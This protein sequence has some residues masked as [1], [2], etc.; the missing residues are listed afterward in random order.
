MTAQHP[1]RTPSAPD[2]D[3]TRDA[4][5]HGGRRPASSK[6]TVGVAAP[7]LLVLAMAPA[8]EAAKR[9]PEIRHSIWSDLALDRRELGNA[10]VL[11]VSPEP[12]AATIAACLGAVEATGRTTVSCDAAPAGELTTVV[13]RLKSLMAS[14]VTTES[15][16]A[17]RESEEK[18]FEPGDANAS[19]DGVRDHATRHAVALALE[20]SRASEAASARRALVVTGPVTMTEVATVVTKVFADD[21][22][23]APTPPPRVFHQTSERLT[24]LD[25]ELTTPLVRT[26]WIVSDTT[27]EEDAALRVA[28]DLLAARRSSRLHRLLVHERS[29]SHFTEAWRVALDGGQLL[30]V[31]FDLSSRASVDRARRFVDGTLKQLRLVGPAPVEFDRAR[32][33]LELDALLSWER[34]ET[35]ARDLVDAEL[36]TGNA[37][38]LL[39]RNAALAGLTRD[40]VR[41]L[42]GARLLD[43]RRTTVEVYPALWPVDD[44]RLSRHSLYTVAAGDTLDTLAARFHV[45]VAQIARAND[46]DPKYGVAVGQPLWIPP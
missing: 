39:A 31:G 10:T 37:G 4:V 15:S 44:P 41:R 24:V 25:A 2:L 26:A 36:T 13:E 40:T 46:L 5:I 14:S 29:L 32:A 17:P 42:S 35:R 11:V 30:G 27:P 18:A 28:F 1:E 34:L 43:S 20:G 12:A 16:I 9:A 6:R 3:S 19:N 23:P 22:V 7:L 21:A 8:A 45:T 33:H 38:R